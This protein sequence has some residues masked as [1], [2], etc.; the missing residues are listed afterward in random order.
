V[1][2]EALETMVELC[3]WALSYSYVNKWFIAT[4]SGT[5]YVR[6]IFIY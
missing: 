1:L 4:I 6:Q 2:G 5:V 3:L